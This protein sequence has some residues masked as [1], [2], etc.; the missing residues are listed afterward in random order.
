V[1]VID[2]RRDSGDMRS[3]GSI[4]DRVAELEAEGVDRKT[5]LKKAAKEFGLS[6]PEAYRILQSG[7]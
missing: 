2:R 6:K 3:E 7:K 1:L 5:A 4:T